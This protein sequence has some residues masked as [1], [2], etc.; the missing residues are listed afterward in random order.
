MIKKIKKLCDGCGVPQ[1]IWKNE[2]GKRFCKQCWSAHSS[3]VS[4]PTVPQKPIPPRSPKRILE[5]AE[6]SAK[7][8]LFLVKH[9]M[10]EAHLAGICTQYATD[11]HH[12]A[13]RLGDLL[14]DIRYWKAVC[15]ACHTW[16]ELHPIEAKEAGLSISRHENNTPMD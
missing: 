8:K 9:P 10:C 7:R 5:D 15:R 2:G 16:I 12:M 1:F 13:G 14:L 11:V 3:K 6:Y 4:K